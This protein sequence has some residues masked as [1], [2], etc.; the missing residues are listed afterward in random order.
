[1]SRDL[2]QGKLA[3]AIWM[4]WRCCQDGALEGMGMSVAI[5]GRHCEAKLFFTSHLHLW[6]LC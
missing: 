4:R 5:K 2:I 6:Q 3:S 1:M